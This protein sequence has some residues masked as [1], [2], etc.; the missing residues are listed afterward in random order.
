MVRWRAAVVAAAAA[1][2]AV[3]TVVVVTDRL[4]LGCVAMV[5]AAAGRERPA[6]PRRGANNRNCFG[7]WMF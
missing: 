1:A 6:A 4:G 7:K 2:A 5:A 3:S